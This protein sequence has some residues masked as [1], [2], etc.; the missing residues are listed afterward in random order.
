MQI[1]K[2]KQ[3]LENTWTYIADDKE[4]SEGNISISAARWKK[5][6]DQLSNRQGKLGIRLQPTDKV[7]EL[8][9]DLEHFSLMEIDFPVYT[10][11]R[12]FSQ[13]RLLR[14]CFNYQGEIRAIG[15]FIADQVFYLSRVGVNSFKLDNENELPL[16]LSTLN[17]FSVSYQTSTH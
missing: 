7:E 5:E 1:I 15:S 8:A 14:D 16:A 12:G 17:D 11:G 4:L 3:I 13:T 9:A 10:D 6:K 2:D